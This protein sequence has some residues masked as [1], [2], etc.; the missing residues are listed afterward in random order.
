MN[1]AK[2]L[3]RDLIA[4]SINTVT[5]YTIQ[6]QE[7]IWDPKR[8]EPETNGKGKSP[9]NHRRYCLP[10]LLLSGEFSCKGN[11]QQRMG[12][13]RTETLKANEMQ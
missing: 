4:A 7:F 3:A 10:A 12:N 8:E 9:E 11:N 5:G 1:K 2:G 6:V 13:I